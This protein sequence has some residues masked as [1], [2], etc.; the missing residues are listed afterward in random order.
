VESSVWS[1]R[2]TGTE[3]AATMWGSVRRSISVGDAGYALLQ[4]NNPIPP[5]PLRRATSNA[6]SISAYRAMPVDMSTGRPVAAHAATS[7][8]STNSN[9]AIFNAGAWCSSRNRTLSSSNADA[10][11]ANPNEE[12]AAASSEYQAHGVIASR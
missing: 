6:A 12:A 7:S 8:R 10:K 11:H 3:N 2:P 9:D 4:R 1:D 5:S